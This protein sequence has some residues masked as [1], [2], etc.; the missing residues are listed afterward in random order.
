MS[1][2]I[3]LL[4]NLRRAFEARLVFRPILAEESKPPCTVTEKANRGHPAG[5]LSYFQAVG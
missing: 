1:V 5:R 4:S 3:T 2:R